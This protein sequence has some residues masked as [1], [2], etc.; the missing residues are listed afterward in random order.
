MNKNILALVVLL[1][2]SFFPSI[3][4]IPLVMAA[5]DSWETLE[6]MPTA[7]CSFGVAVVDGKIYAIGGWNGS[8]LNTNEMYDPATDTWTTKRSMPTARSGHAIAVYQNK[9]YIIGGV[10]GESDP[11]SSGYTGITEVYDPLT[12]TWETMEPMPTARGDL[13]ANV[14]DEKIYLIEG[15]KYW[16]VFPFYQNV[17]VNEVYDPSNNS[18]STKTPIPTSTFGYASAVADNKIYV[19][20]GPN[21]DGSLNQIYDPETDTWTS[22]T[23]ALAVAFWFSAAGA[24]TGVLSPKRIYVLGGV[25]EDADALSQNYVYDHAEDVWTTG[26]TMLTPRWALGVAVVNDE[27][28]AIG[29]YDGNTHLAVNEKYTPLGYIPEFPSWFVLPLFLFVSLVAVIVRRRVTYPKSQ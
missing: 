15:R 28:Y 12:D 11:V 8:Y 7:R 24:T 10:I 18:W 25:D 13:C 6:P 3:L 1:V 17:D 9:I 23:P 19:M 26:T 5:E 20:G 14:V 16:G 21:P 2:V 22:G 4:S 27:L 29:G